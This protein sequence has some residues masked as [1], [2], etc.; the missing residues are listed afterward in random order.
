MVSYVD[1]KEKSCLQ[2][3][4]HGQESNITLYSEL[5]LTWYLLSFILSYTVKTMLVY[6]S[7]F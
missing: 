6:Y 5:L 3:R 7:K 4:W 2:I 1:G